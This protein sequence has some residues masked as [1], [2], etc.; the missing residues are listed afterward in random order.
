MENNGLLST[1][2]VETPEPSY[3]E[4][5]K[6][7][8]N[9]RKARQST[10]VPSL[11]LVI[12]LSIFFGFLG[13]SIA[14]QLP[15]FPRKTPMPTPPKQGIASQSSPQPT[16]QNGGVTA[17]DVPAVS[18]V[19]KA[20][21]AVVS[22]VVSKDVS[23]IQQFQNPLFPFFADPFGGMG[24]DGQQQQ[25]SQKNGNSGGANIQ[26][27]GSGSGFIVSSDGLV[28]T[29]KHVVSDLQAEYTVT[30]EGGKE[31][32]A[33]V[34]ARDPNHDIAVLKIDGTDFPTL[35]IGD[36]DTLKVGQTVIA[37][38]NPLGEFA[39]SVSRGIV[40]GLKRS[41]TAGSGLGG[42]AEQLTDIIQTDAAI[43]P[44]NSGGPLLDLS[45]N[46]VGVNAAIAQGAE[47]IGFAL[48]INQVKKVIDQV[49]QT[50]KISTPYLG[51]RY[52][53]LNGDIQKQDALP[54]D[55]GAIVL[56][57]A[58]MTDFAVVPG[59]PADKAGIVEN[60]I[61]L[62]ADGTKIDTDHPL[63]GILADK[64]VGDTVTLSV[65]HKGTTKDITVTLEERKQ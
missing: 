18:V 48:S 17:E 8:P 53:I 50:G 43:N 10:P 62:L 5:K 57:G 47:N 15:G 39:N 26:Q 2:T 4:E 63:A 38:G 32:P 13:G 56:R 60:D 34:L 25:P 31:Y 49:K 64:N 29:N 1:G 54:F 6:N 41:V 44:G 65:W 40:S 28:V 52:I 16:D 45:G 24:M 42:D 36:S 20:S 46:V 55:Y 22:V 27:I 35:S 23:K 61:I 30:L 9:P 37:I 59:S 11:V 12:I 33:K 14:P 58:T 51:V 3:N 19:E 21:P 7:V